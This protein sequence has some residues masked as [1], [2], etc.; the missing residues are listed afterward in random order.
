M[1]W[2]FESLNSPIMRLGEETEAQSSEKTGQGHSANEQEQND[3]NP[4]REHRSP[5]PLSILHPKAWVVVEAV[6]GLCHRP[7]LP[8]CPQWRV[9]TLM[10]HSVQRAQCLLSSPRSPRRETALQ[11]QAQGR[12]QDQPYSGAPF[13]VSLTPSPS[14][15]RAPRKK[16]CVFVPEHQLLH[17]GPRPWGGGTSAAL[18]FSKPAALPRRSWASAVQG[19]LESDPWLWAWSPWQPRIYDR[20]LHPA[21]WTF[22]TF[23]LKREEGNQEVSCGSCEPR[24]A[25]RSPKMVSEG[26]SYRPG[27]P[28]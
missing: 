11:R 8:P 20:S 16:Q 26:P 1:C 10:G 15:E 13:C 21:W 18:C 24:A 9:M 14:P 17:A 2:L 7:E 22:W 19:K 25:P 12:V 4:V 5:C 27:W 6:T 23:D 28:G 3:W